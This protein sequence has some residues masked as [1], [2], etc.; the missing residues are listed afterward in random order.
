MAWCLP[1]YMY[2][3]ISVVVN[4]S[5]S[6]SDTRYWLSVVSDMKE[7]NLNS[8]TFTGTGKV[9]LKIAMSFY[10]VVEFYMY[11]YHAM[12]NL[13]DISPIAIDV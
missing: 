4:T 6:V 10:A 5:S 11:S 3:I 7:A 8:A 1:G 2:V 12:L 13:A 9:L